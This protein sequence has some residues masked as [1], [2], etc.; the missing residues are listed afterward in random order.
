MERHL[1]RSSPFL[2]RNIN[3]KR[4]R[5]GAIL[6]L[7]VGSIAVL[8]IL[9]LGA[10]SNVLSELKVAKLVTDSNTSFYLAS[11]VIKAMRVVF[12]H[13]PASGAITLYDLQPREIPFGERIVQVS[14]SDEQTKINIDTA[15]K[16]VLLRLPGL[17]EQEP[18]VDAIIASDIEAKE[19]L[20]LFEGMTQE[21]Y[22]A[23]KNLVTTITNG[24]IN[25][26]TADAEIFFILG[27][28]SDL[29]SKIQIFRAG[30][31][32][33]EGTE[34]DRYFP[35]EAEIIPLLEA[36]GLNPSQKTLLESMLA[37]QALSIT[38]DFINFGMTVKKAGRAT[39]GVGK[40]LRTFSV[41]LQLAS[42]SIASWQES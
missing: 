30:E 17:A 12:A 18:L 7:A 35:G 5:R 15:P 9:A 2:L 34:D 38:S 28:D 41:L 13:D 21:I 4:P 32:A 10:T 22:D 36:Y 14:F 25:I 8:S 6:F 11:S 39:G 29:I 26:N 16:A 27:M 19:E 37:S 20:L 33:I 23:M 1:K 3:R 24:S 42:G 40:P 31:D